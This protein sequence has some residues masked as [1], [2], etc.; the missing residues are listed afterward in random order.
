MKEWVKG[1]NPSKFRMEITA[2]TGSSIIIFDGTY[3]Y[4]YDPVSK[5]AMKMS[6]ASAASYSSSSS[7]STA[8]NTYNPVYIGSET[9]NGVDCSVYSYTTAGVVTKMWIS[10]ANGMTIRVVSGTSTMDYTN[11]SFASIP[12][13][14]FQ[15]PADAILISI[16]G[17]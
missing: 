9:V 2:A 14:T 6:A 10:K 3:N 11:Y 12:D 7:N 4:F 16:P 17:Q 8:I 1:G 15:L 13:S 5:T